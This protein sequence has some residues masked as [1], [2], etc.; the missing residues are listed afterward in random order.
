MRIA[1]ERDV[2]AMLMRGLFLKIFLWFWL[3]LMLLVVALLVGV[4]ATS[5]DENAGPPWHGLINSA[6][7]THAL[8]AAAA[9]EQGG[10]PA[11][12]PYLAEVRR[13]ARVEAHL[14]Y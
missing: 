7:R 4:L 11:L 8:N 9:F 1:D 12:D 13:T 14:F 3:S 6:V 5:S 2:N 10:R